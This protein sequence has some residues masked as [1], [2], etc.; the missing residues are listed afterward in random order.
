MAGYRSISSMIDAATC[1][2]LFDDGEDLRGSMIIDLA[3]RAGLAG[4]Q[5]N[6]LLRIVTK[7]NAQRRK[8][9]SIRCDGCGK[10]GISLRFGPIVGHQT[11]CSSCAA[12]KIAQS[13]I[14]QA[15]FVTYTDA[16]E[17]MLPDSTNADYDLSDYYTDILDWSEYGTW[18]HPHP[19][20]AVKRSIRD[21]YYPPGQI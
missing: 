19:Q 11:Y 7:T 20:D 1:V 21:I 8:A 17:I 13:N 10:P 16:T 14:G 3:A 4:K 2:I 9:T 18:E 15:A 5:G 12:R 6:R